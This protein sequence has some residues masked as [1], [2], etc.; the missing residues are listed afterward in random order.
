MARDVKT[1]RR[2]SG[3]HCG[4][5]S[6]AGS[7]V[8]R[9]DTP[10]ARSR[11]HRSLRSA[12]V[13]D[14]VDQTLAVGRQ[15]RVAVVADGVDRRRLLAAAIDPHQPAPLQLAGTKREHAVARHGKR[16]QAHVVD[17]EALAERNGFAFE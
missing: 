11:I 13:G 15:R 6:S 1:M 17:A 16:R 9:D 2:P 3:D 12:V 5:S 7:K 10:R 14:V 4:S 8:K